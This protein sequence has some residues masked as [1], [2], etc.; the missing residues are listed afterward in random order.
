MATTKLRIELCLIVFLCISAIAVE[1]LSF[2]SSLRP[3]SET[4]A[5]WFQRSGAITSVFASFAQYRIGSFLESIRGGTFA[6]S[7]SLYHLF[8]AH[9]YV[10]SWVI[11]IIAIWGALVWGYGDLLIKY[12]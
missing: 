2:C 7:W 10:L 8:K 12:V 9:H 1:L 6:E 5:S 3:S 4:L 11:A